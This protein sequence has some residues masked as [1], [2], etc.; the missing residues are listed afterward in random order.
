M[1]SLEKLRLLSIRL[2][3][4][5]DEMNTIIRGFNEMLAEV[6]VGV[7]TW[8]P[9]EY[10]GDDIWKFGYGRHGANWML[11]AQSQDGP[12]MNLT[13]APRS[14]RVVAVGLLPGIILALEK[15][16]EEF[17]EAIDGANDTLGGT[18]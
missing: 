4:K 11:L 16:T 3:E 1:S 10:V 2:N 12:P 17:I 18:L 13:G 8:L 5:S 14:A 9:A 6:G 7:S 15:K